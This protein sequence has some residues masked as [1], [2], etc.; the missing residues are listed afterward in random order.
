MSS[1]YTDIICHGCGKSVQY[2]KAFFMYE[3]KCCSISCL[4]PLRIKRQMEEN[5]EE[6]T[7]DAKRAK[8]GAFTFGGGGAA[9]C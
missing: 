3:F 1:V 8:C 9:A 5:I 6:E 4:N 2:N 7:H